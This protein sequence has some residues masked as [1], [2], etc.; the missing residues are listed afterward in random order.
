VYAFNK[1]KT[2]IMKNLLSI[3]TRFVILLCGLYGI[4]TYSAYSQT[5][6][7]LFVDPGEY[8]SQ[9]GYQNAERPVFYPYSDELTADEMHVLDTL[10]NEE[11]KIIEEAFDPIGIGVVRDLKEPIIFNLSKVAIPSYGEVTVAGGRLSRIDENLLVYTIFIQSKRA[12]EIRVFFERGIFP[13]GVEVN[14]FSGEQFAFTQHELRGTLDEYGIYTTSVD[15]DHLLIQVVIQLEVIDS[16]VYFEITR[17]THVDHIYLIEEGDRTCTEDANCSYANGYTGITGLRRATARLSWPVGGGYVGLCSGAL[18]NDVREKDWQPYLLTANHCF[19]SQT[20]ANALEARFDYWSTSCNS[21]VV[22]PSHIIINGSNLIATN[23]QSDITLVLLK[24]QPGGAR[25]WLGWTTGSV[26][27]NATLHSTHHPGG[28][29]MKYSRHQN[30]TSPSPLC[31]GVPTSNYHYTRT[32]GGRTAGGSSGG[33][34]VNPSNQ[35]VGQ[36]L[37]I[38][39]DYGV[40]CDYTT[41]HNAW[42][43]FS[44]SYD[45]NNLQFWLYTSLGA[46]GVAMSTSP[47]SALSFGTRNV[48]SNTN[49]TVT[50]TNTGTRPNYLNLEAGNIT[51][52]G[53]NAS[54]FSIIG[55][56]FLYLAPQESGTFTIR[57]TPT[58]SGFKTANLNIPHN[59][60][61]I[62]ASPRVITLTGTG[63]PCS[64]VI[65][66]GGG[67]TANTKTF[68]KSGTGAWYNSTTNPCNYQS[69]GREQVYS[70]IA[71]RTGIYSIQVTSTNS[72]WVDYM[73]KSGSCSSTGW[74]CIS[75]VYSPGIYGAM[76]MTAGVTYYILLDA[77]TI[78][79]STHTFFVFLNPCMNISNIAGTGSGNSQT[80][81]GGGNGA[82]FTG[83]TNPC[84]Y[85]S[86]G[87]EKV[88][89]FTAPYTGY[90]SIQVTS[91]TGGW[92]DY[93]WKSGACSSAGWQCIG[94]VYFPGKYGSMYWTAGTTY[95]IL[96]DSEYTVTGSQTFYINPPDP[97]NGVIPIAGCGPGNSITFSSTGPGVWNMIDVCGWATP[98]AEQIYSFTAPET[99]QYSIM[100]TSASGSYVDYMWK[101]GSC[102]SSD[103]TCIG[104]FASAGQ[105]ASITWTAGTTYHILLDPEVT[106]TVSQSFH[107]VC[108]QLCQPDCVYDFLISPTTSWQLHASSHASSYGCKIYRF[109]AISGRTY[110]FQTACGNGATANYDTYMFLYNN[111]NCTQIASNDDACGSSGSRIEWTA[112]YTGYA[113]VK[114]RG[115][116][117]AG[118]D[119]TMAYSYCTSAPSQPGAITGPA[120][121]CNGSTNTYSIAA[122]SGVIDYTWT[123]PAG[124]TGSSTTNTINATAGTNGGNISVIANNSC[125][126]SPPRTLSVSVL[127][128]P[129]QPGAISG[130]NSICQ[131]TTNTYSISPVP[132]AASYNWSLP[133]GWTGS[134]TGTSINATA[135][136]NSGSISVSA[137]N[138][139]GTSPSS[140]LSVAVTLIP[141]Q[142][143]SITGPANVLSGTTHT[144]SIVPVSG[145]TS[146]TWA[147][148]GAGTPVGSGTSINL[149]PTSN[150]VLSVTS[151]NFCGSST[152]RSKTITVY[153]VPLNRNIQNIIVGSGQTICYDA[154]QT[155]TTAG[156]GTLFIVQSNSVVYLVAGQNIVMLPGTHLQNGSYV[157]AY[158]ELGDE[159]CSNPKTIIATQEDIVTP[160]V[161]LN[162]YTEKAAFFKVFPNPTRGSFTLELD[163]VLEFSSINIEIYNIIGEKILSLEL[164]EFKQYEFDLTDQQPGVFLIR[165]LRGDQLGVEKIIRQ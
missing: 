30:K 7:S 105:Y 2:S 34:I 22:N 155:I 44:V 69:P 85:I 84:G 132:G 149:T 71:P 113:Y 28:T 5:D 93:L 158:I 108:P 120:T 128:T 103:W 115:W 66:L 13:D 109:T 15:A 140:L 130:P 144:Y 114:I 127:V 17:I 163:E 87:I 54:Q 23:S 42:G 86:P 156:G 9:F 112:D 59:A 153:T 150:G 38:C 14:I 35:I 27:N 47:E 131:G 148:S 133:A 74:N 21:G 96:A 90:Y 36:L 97:C 89:S 52:T 56:T 91:A 94:D 79:L 76:S 124:W 164:P 165:V 46:N 1:P 45:N 101:S 8:F 100:I 160:E 143:G 20:N 125:G 61:N 39:P 135:G 129:A 161:P 119:Y 32:L 50:V 137:S 40:H 81:T 147:Y 3:A 62:G 146:Y 141:A 139:C 142:P 29:L 68:S 110:T 18:I 102:S 26:D 49:L 53:T 106:S 98:G 121:V 117:G 60:D 159:Y 99:G 134:S 67:G 63:N 72:K 136:T 151:N 31:N 138:I 82:W 65:S 107:I 116:A 64:E 11:R 80:Y 152:A 145:A 58:S 111:A 73:W 16:E 4:S 95:H 126:S 118:G 33:P 83:S 55:A 78:D 24:Q 122:M 6:D 104:T 157:H 25:S 10:T 154:L 43:K 70:F 123:L 37:G 88:Y 12:D 57:F 51:I 48:G 41:Y 77:E 92:V 19:S 75:D 162:N